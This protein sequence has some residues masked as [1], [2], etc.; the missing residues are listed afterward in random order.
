MGA[1]NN[2]MPY[3]IYYSLNLR[4]LEETG[5]VIQL[6]DRS[7][8]YPRGVMEDVLVQVNELV[9]LADFYILDIEEKHPQPNTNLVG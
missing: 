2:V 8:V 1:S 3:S 7:N 9:F 4:P 5:V 6:T